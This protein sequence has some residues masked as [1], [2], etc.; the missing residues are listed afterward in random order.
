MAAQQY[1]IVV[2]GRLSERLGSAFRDVT[3]ERHTGRTVLRGN[4]QQAR[5]DSV[6]TRL[7]DLGIEPLEVDNHD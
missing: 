1:R 3:L 6:L 7:N 5:L 4:Q 2:R